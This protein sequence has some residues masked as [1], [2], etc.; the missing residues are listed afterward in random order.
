MEKG[1]RIMDRRIKRMETAEAG[2]NGFALSHLSTFD[3]D[4][5]V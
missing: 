3:G 2:L 1:D 4:L 5:A